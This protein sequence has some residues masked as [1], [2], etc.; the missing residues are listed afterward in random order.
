MTESALMAA[1][2]LI[3]NLRNF[4][5]IGYSTKLLIEWPSC[6]IQMQLR[7]WCLCKEPRKCG[8]KNGNG[9]IFSSSSGG[10]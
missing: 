1:G 10:V 6:I 9:F 8:Y 4:E 2:F 3:Y 5:S 7:D